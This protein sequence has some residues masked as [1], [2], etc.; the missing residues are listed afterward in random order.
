[1]AL[2]PQPERGAAESTA[3]HYASASNPRSITLSAP[4]S[5]RAKGGGG[6]L[7]TQPEKQRQISPTTWSNLVLLKCP[8]RRV[9]PGPLVKVG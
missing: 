4:P 5:E 7:F 3:T 8:A 9:Y 6:K 2:R 1:M